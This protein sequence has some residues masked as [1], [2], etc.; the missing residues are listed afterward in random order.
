M[1]SALSSGTSTIHGC[2]EGLDVRATARIMSQL[3]AQITEVDRT[4]E[5]TGPAE[6]LMSA[7][8][9]LDCENSGTT[10]RLLCGLLGSV[11]GTNR[12]IGDESLSRRPMDRVAAPLSLMGIHIVGHGDRVTAPLSVSRSPGS[13]RAITYDV[14]VPSAQVKSAVLF[15]ALSGDGP[16]TVH[17]ATRTRATT[18][19]MLQRAGITL[20]VQ[21]SASGRTVVIDPGRPVATRWTVPADPSQAAFF[22]VLAAIHPNAE[23]TIVDLYD[24]AERTGFLSVL[25]RMG[26]EITR[27]VSA[28]EVT[29]TVTS[30]SL[31][32]TTVESREIPSLDEV[33]VLAVA[34]AAADGES[35]FTDVAELRVKESNRLAET[36]ELIRALGATALEDGDDLVIAGVG[37]SRAFRP[38]HYH[39][40][41][42][43][44]MVM[45]AAVAAT[46][47]SG[48]TLDGAEHVSSS[49]PTF[50]DELAGLTQ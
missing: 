38:F 29:I 25:E 15:A 7:E 19:E 1:I 12:L 3:G 45:A 28:D 30:A 47:G 48:G 22:A 6:G 10:M 37:S 2:S 14:P 11:V 24:S 8:H 18:E 44:R 32:A 13:L 31:R 4:L 33:P 40:P 23:L 21:S 17:E 34:A 16:T 35:R 5:V 43:H 50:F 9:E 46:A 27:D 36:V 49:Y 26:A 20:S 39:A 42:D 41:N